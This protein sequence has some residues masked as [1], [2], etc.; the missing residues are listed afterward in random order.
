MSATARPQ[1]A[2]SPGWEGILDAGESVLWQGRP[3]GKLTFGLSDAAQGLF[4]LAFAAFAL[5]WMIMASTAGG[6]F[7]AFGLIHFSVGVG[8]AIGGPLARTFRLRRTWY[9]LTTRRAFIASD[10][11]I[12]GRS[13]AAY[14]INA[15]STLALV[16]GS[17][18]TVYFAEVTRR[19]KNGSRNVPLG[20]E[21]IHDARDVLAQMRAI[22]KEAK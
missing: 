14:P 18:G 10:T 9:T 3:D 6:Y 15:D 12:S 8:L 1:T 17:P 21:R 13:L 22:Q 19:S 7:W 11:L 4:G 16:E 5:F 20:F 2:T